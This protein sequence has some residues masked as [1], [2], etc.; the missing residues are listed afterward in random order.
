MLHFNPYPDF[1]VLSKYFKFQ[2]LPEELT[3]QYPD[4]YPI[5]IDWY[6]T[7]EKVAH[8]EEG[9]REIIKKYKLESS[10]DNLLFLSLGKLQELDSIQYELD[11]QFAQ[12]KRTKELATLLLFFAESS[13]YQIHTILFKTNKKSAPIIDKKLIDWIQTIIIQS[14]KDG[15]MKLTDFEYGIMD[16]FFDERKEQL[17]LNKLKI[18]ATQSLISSKK[19]EKRLIADFCLYLYMYL[20]NETD[21]KPNPNSLFSDAMLNF[22]FDLLTLYELINPDRIQSEPKDY[23][24]T[25]L[26]NRIKV[27]NPH[28]QGNK[29]R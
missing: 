18:A 11:F 3:Q 16:A 29:L 21:I 14:I 2:H 9:F 25:L 10:F 15:K 5:V 7:E 26:K 6:D 12:K 20:V 23:L 17:D 8:I 28:Y 13:P 22:F 24:G 19:E 4:A 27:L 1:S